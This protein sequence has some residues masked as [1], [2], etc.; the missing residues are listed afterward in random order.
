MLLTTANSRP[1][2]ASV[3]AF[4]KEHDQCHL[5]KYTRSQQAMSLQVAHPQRFPCQEEEQINA[6][7]HQRFAI[8]T[9]SCVSAVRWTYYM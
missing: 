1:W 3:V 8:V 4:D 6:E 9:F 7:P 2:S 5:A